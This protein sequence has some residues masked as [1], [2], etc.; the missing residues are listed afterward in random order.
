VDAPHDGRYARAPELKDLLALCRA[1]NQ[2]GVQYILIGGFA[3]ILQGFVRGTKDIDI[4]VDPSLENVQRI[5]QALSY[6][7]DNAVSSLLDNEI[8]KYEVVRVADEIVVD[9]MAKACGIDYQSACKH[10]EHR[11]VQSITIPLATKDLLIRMKQTQ[12]PSDKMDVEF[13]L[14][15]IEADKK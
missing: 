2:A 6:L 14:H 5:R 13:L 11:K 9:L 8:R 3:V 10:I 7:P 12:R 15:R 4:L 1:L